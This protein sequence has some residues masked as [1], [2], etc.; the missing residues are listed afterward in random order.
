MAMKM[1]SKSL[2][3]PLIWRMGQIHLQQ[4]SHQEQ[5]LI[6]PARAMKLCSESFLK[7]LIWRMWQFH[8][9]KTRFFTENEI[10]CLKTVEND[11]SYEAGRQGEMIAYRYFTEKLGEAAVKWLNRDFEM[12]LPYDLIIEQDSKR[13]MWRSKAPFLRRKTGS[14]YQQTSGTVRSRRKNHS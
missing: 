11:R 6:F 9:W 14:I 1:W 7:P 10:L 13:Y 12:G 2:Q 8:L 3:K 4:T 5:I